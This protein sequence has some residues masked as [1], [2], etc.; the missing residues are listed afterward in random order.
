MQ[1]RTPFLQQMWHTQGGPLA[2]LAE[3]S[4]ASQAHI[5]AVFMVLHNL[6]SNCPGFISHCS[7]F[8]WGTIRQPSCP[9]WHGLCKARIS[10][11]PFSLLC[12]VE[13]SLLYFPPSN[14]CLFLKTIVKCNTHTEKKCIKY[15][16]TA[17]WIIIKQISK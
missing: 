16:F 7:L 11:M 1:N 10:L 6:V 8:C 15:K 14:F 2:L 3:C 5:V 17:L 13:S 12:L 4:T 9:P